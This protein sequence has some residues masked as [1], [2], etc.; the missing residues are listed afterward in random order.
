LSTSTPNPRLTNTSEAD[1]SLTSVDVRQHGAVGDGRTDDRAAFQRAIDAAAASGRVVNVPAGVYRIESS[2]SFASTSGVTQFAR[3]GLR[4]PA[5]VSLIGQPGA[6]LTEAIGYANRRVTLFIAGSDVTI[7]SL[8]VRNLYD[9]TGGSRPTSV[10]VGS[11]D[12]FDP[13]L[14]GA[15]ENVTIRDCTF[16]RAWHPTKFAF[17]QPNGTATA[18]NIRIINCT[19]THETAPPITGGRSSGGFNFVSSTPSRISEVTVQGCTDRDSAVSAGVGLYGVTDATVSGC[20][21]S[22]A[23]LNGA[24]I[25][26]ENGAV[27]VS[28]SGNTLVNN[29]NGIWVDDSANVAILGNTI[30]N[31]T[32]NALFKGVRITWQGFTEGPSAVTTDIIVSGNV[33]SN[34]RVI[35]EPF[36]TP[37]GSPTLGSVLIA[38]NSVRLDGITA[39]YGLLVTTPESVIV[40]GNRI[41]GAA[42]SSIKIAARTN[43]LIVVSGNI[44]SRTATEKS[45]GLEISGA[46]AFRPVV[47]DN[48]F[49]NDP[50]TLPASSSGVI[51]ISTRIF[52]GAGS[53]EGKISAPVGSLYTRVDGGRTTAFYVKESGTGATGWIAK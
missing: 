29:H 25:Q 2:V 32:P 12:A 37:V 5:G 52:S 53:P 49:I 20:I 39:P 47:T 51:G 27:N 3:Y 36:S 31:D 21:V 13:S 16:L 46:G 7:A 48:Q 4:I 43:T 40:R 34:C 41:S 22:N 33:L 44:T 6:I 26:L 9:Q 1:L 30:R 8:T 15:I 23:G 18:R 24:G 11:G 42:T 17:H 19:A 10:M 28:V 38:D 50:A 35:A 45:N 14:R